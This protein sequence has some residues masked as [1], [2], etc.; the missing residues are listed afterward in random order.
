[1]ILFTNGYDCSKPD[2]SKVSDQAIEWL[3]KK[4][5][6][7]KG[8]TQFLYNILESWEL[9]MELEDS[10]KSRGVMLCPSDYA[11]CMYYIALN[12]LKNA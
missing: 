5:N 12:R 6:R 1:M 8:Q 3:S 10:L 9:L 2:P 7:A 11:E 4:T